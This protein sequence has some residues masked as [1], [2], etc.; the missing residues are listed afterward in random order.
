MT[1]FVTAYEQNFMSLDTNDVGSF[2]ACFS[3]YFRSPGGGRPARQTRTVEVRAGELNVG[4]LG[5]WVPERETTCAPSVGHGWLLLRVWFAG[6]WTQRVSQREPGAV[7]PEIVVDRVCLPWRQEVVTHGRAALG[8]AGACQVGV[9]RPLRALGRPVP[10]GGWPRSAATD[11]TGLVGQRS[12]L[13]DRGSI[14]D[15]F[16]VLVE[17]D[18]ALIDLRSASAKPEHTMRIRRKSA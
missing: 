15:R 3:R 13:R 11:A 16:L 5:S 18:L 7:I 12:R 1:S 2:S 9:R 6:R 10:H 17:Q 8:A 4:E 14:D